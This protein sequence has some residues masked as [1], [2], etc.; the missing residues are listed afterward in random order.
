MSTGAHVLIAGAGLG[1]LGLAQGLK[2]HGIRCTVFERDAS[3]DA[4]AQGYRIKVFPDTVPDLKFLMSGDLFAEFEAT[5]AET[6]MRETTIS[7]VDGRVTMRRALRGPKPYTVDRGFLRKV[8]L[9]GLEDQIQ[10]GKE[11]ARYEIDEANSPDEPVTLHFTDGSSA[12]GTLLIGAEGGHSPV[13]KQH[14]PKHRI[15]D[16]EA[17]CIYGRTH[18]TPELEK[19]IQ[20]KMLQ[21][22]TVIRDIAPVIQQVIFA[23]ELP[24][25]M[26]VERMHFPQRDLA[27]R[28]DLPEDYVYWSM[29]APSKLVGFTEDMVAAAVKSKTPRQLGEALTEEWDDSTK[30]LVDLQDDSYAAALRVISSTPELSEWETSQYVT[31][32]GDAVHV[33][34]PSGGVGAATSLKDAVALT[35]SL[36]GADGFSLASIKEYEQTMKDNAKVAI[37]RSFRG[38]KLFYGQPPLEQC[39][40]LSDA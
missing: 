28:D 30:C 14:V 6:V 5:S 40:V 35:K 29:L 26:F 10:W 18:L 33:M 19:R 37:D 2:K 27:G 8:L 12:K 9:K 24:V 11:V 32:V 17:V 15:V 16:P 20:P 7:A 1:G 13:R 22:L 3:P 39:R 25:T 23:S 4:R 36:T 38:G 31:L 21:S 34:S